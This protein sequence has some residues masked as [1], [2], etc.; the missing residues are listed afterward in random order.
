MGKKVKVKRKKQDVLFVQTSCLE[1]SGYVVI[2]VINGI[3]L[4]VKV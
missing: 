2:F 3:T 1:K 4:D